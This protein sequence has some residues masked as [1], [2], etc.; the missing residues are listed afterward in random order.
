MKDDV[1]EFERTVKKFPERT[2][3]SPYKSP[4]YVK[5]EEAYAD[6]WEGVWAKVKRERKARDPKYLGGQC[7]LI[8]TDLINEHLILPSE[9]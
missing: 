2:I 1:E 8:T 9:I 6:D 3:G 4:F 7:R 5:K